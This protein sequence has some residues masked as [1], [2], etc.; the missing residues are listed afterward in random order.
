VIRRSCGA[1]LAAASDGGNAAAP[2]VAD[3]SWEDD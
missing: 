3:H 1:Q 2:A